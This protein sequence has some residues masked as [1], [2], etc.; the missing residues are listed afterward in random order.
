LRLY[1]GARFI[2]LHSEQLLAND[3]SKKEKKF[4]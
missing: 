1:N 4:S 2:F 3:D